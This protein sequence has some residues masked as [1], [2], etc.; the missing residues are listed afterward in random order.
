MS[1]LPGKAY[2]QQRQ[3]NRL[4]DTII[5]V[6]EDAARLDG[7]RKRDLAEK[8]GTSP[9]QIS[10][11]LSGPSNWTIDSISDVLWS[12]GGE[13]NFNFV[14]FQDQPQ[15]NSSHPTNALTV[16]TSSHP[17]SAPS[18]TNRM[19]G[20]ELQTSSNVPKVNITRE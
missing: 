3:R 14:R 6:V 13:L 18:T 20:H 15:G 12:V 5:R 16:L 4:Y 8:M 19:L 11:W 2:F 1:H 7:I 17:I 9:S 10:R